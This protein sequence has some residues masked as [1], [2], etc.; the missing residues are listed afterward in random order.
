MRIV[1]ILTLLALSAC[2]RQKPPASITC[3]E[4]PAVN[5]SAIAWQRMSGNVVEGLVTDVHGA[6][7][8]GA[9][10]QLS[11]AR[12]SGVTDKDGRL[13][14]EGVPAREHL[15]VARAIGYVR[16]ERTI[17]LGRDDG[18]R[19]LAVLERAPSGIIYDCFGAGAGRPDTRPS[20]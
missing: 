7:L 4:P 2:V 18:A 1:L 14:I 12:F 15:I 13:H 5:G 16:A 9:L 6:P 17:S 19:I 8:T 3:G 20:E 10:V 11:G